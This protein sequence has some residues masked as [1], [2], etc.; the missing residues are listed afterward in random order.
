MKKGTRRVLFWLAVLVFAG[1]SAVAVLFAQGYKYDFTRRVFVRT[2]GIAVTT[3]VDATLTVNGHPAS[4]MSFLAHSTGVDRLLPGTYQVVVTK[5]NYSTWK[6]TAAVQEGLLTD[7]P[8]ILLLPTD[9]ASSASL[10]AEITLA[11]KQSLTV[12]D[13]TPTPT[14]SP[15]P[16]TRTRKP[17]PTPTPTEITLNDFT[18]HNTTLTRTIDGQPTVIADGVLGFALTDNN[19]RILWWTPHELW[20]LWIDNTDYQPYHVA[21]DRERISPFSDAITRAAW[22][23]DRDHIVVDVGDQGYR[24]VETDTRDSVNT[25]SITK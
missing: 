4:A 14:V 15:T 18:L 3:N 25:I 19:D 11:L 23:R 1:A 17:S 24:V 16:R 13:A 21:D 7:F 6:K 2:G 8:H 10:R 9:R 20:V 12:A 22:F 5:D